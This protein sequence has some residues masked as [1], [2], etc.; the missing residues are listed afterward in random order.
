MTTPPSPE[1]VPAASTVKTKRRRLLAVGVVLALGLGVGAWFALRG[2]SDGPPE[3]PLPPEISEVEV[4]RVVTKARAKVVE[5][6][7][8]ANAWGDYAYVLLAHLFDRDAD[9]CL[10]QAAK[11]NPSDPRW[12]HA[13]AMIALKRE[14][15]KAADYLRQAAIAAG[16]N[17][18]FRSAANLTLAETLLEQRDIDAAAELFAKELAA[19]PRQARATFGL[20]L[21]AL[22]KND[23][24]TAKRL[25][26]SVAENPFCQKQAAVHLAAFARI[27]GDD[28]T[29]RQ[30]EKQ[31]N[32][33]PADP[34]WPDPVLDRL[35]DLRVGRRGRDRRISQ[36]ELNG[37]FAEAV[38]EYQTA[39]ED[40]RTAKNLVGAGVN[41]A[42]LGEYERALALI[43]EGI[44]VDPN[45]SLAHYTLA[46]VLYTR[47]EK[48]GGGLPFK[49][50][51]QE[52]V[53][54][55]KRTVELKPDHANAYLFWGLAL[56]QLGD[57]SGAIE[58]LRN[59]LTVRPDGF[60]LHLAL[61]QALA[62]T[63]N[64]TEAARS[65]ENARRIN[66]DDPRPAEALERLRE[67]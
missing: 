31:A 40:E 60:D 45:D 20:G 53:I 46:L 66:P 50:Q 5:K 62:A 38:Q 27:Q 59:G 44:Q 4:N 24:A 2:K 16:T 51:F 49:D 8:S 13:R 47:A 9:I 28:A 64:K 12:P 3:P 39:L 26:A 33:L 35:L 34:P 52:V 29:A 11:L 1:P 22:A 15:T 41:L 21:V 6:P 32:E 48:A 25:F 54:E 61:G 36:L 58:P 67:K 23:D 57:F 10:A 43:R 14:P 56:K 55:A 37:Q 42:R 19:D 18:K 7:D 17:A 63:G 65:F 30:Y